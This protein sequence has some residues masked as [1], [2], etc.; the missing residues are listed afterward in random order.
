MKKTL[1]ALAVVAASNAY[2]QSSVTVF[3]IIDNAF[4]I[5]NGSIANKTSLSSPG[6]LGS[7]FGFRGSEDL[8]NGVKANFWL[9]A[10]FTSDDGMGALSSAN[11]QVP[12]PTVAVAGAQGLTFNRRSFVSVASTMGELQLGRDYTPFFI[13]NTTYDPFGSSGS[14]TSRAF[15]GTAGAYSGGNTVAVRASNM[16]SYTTPQLGG[17][18]AQVVTY[19]GENASN[20]AA[21]TSPGSGSGLRLAY[22]SGPVSVALGWN[23]VGLTASS[24]VNSFN[25]GG[26][27]D[28]GVAKVRAFYSSD[29]LSAAAR[30]VKGYLLGATVPLGSGFVRASYSATNNGAATAAETKQLALGYVYSMSKRTDIYVNLVSADNSGG[31]AAALNGAVTAPNAS[32][33][34]FD[35]GIKHTF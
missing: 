16:I 5:G 1:L 17:F 2:A 9:E 18:A 3:G 31:A 33:S 11:N 21:G 13:V 32:S 20:D 34:A 28:F 12:A 15:L 23:K 14:G 6:Y 30:V 19:F 10:G 22:A 7:R 25:V 35:L 29:D 8:G 4:S 24:E 26:S 27:Y